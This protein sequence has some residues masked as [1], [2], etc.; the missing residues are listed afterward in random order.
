VLKIVGLA[1]LVLVT[2]ILVLPAFRPDTFRVQRG[3]VVKAPPERIVAE[4]ADFHGWSAWSPWE[5]MDPAMKR[6]YGGAAKGKGATYAW[7]SDKV[8][9][10]G[11][12][13]TDV[14]PSRVALDLDFV[15]PF[16]AHNKV[17]FTLAPA[18]KTEAG[19][20]TEVTW[21]MSGPVPYFFR[22]VHLFM[23]MDQMVGKD[24]ET[25]LANLKAVVEK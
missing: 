3:T 1:V 20:A 6:N 7:E 5:K 19:D 14:T 8:G 13:I 11:M 9:H 25:G 12:A 23:N 15:K 17:D 4:L 18:G 2:V 16:E 10:G 22:L 24:F 21:A